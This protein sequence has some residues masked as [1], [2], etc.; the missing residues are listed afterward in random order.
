[1]GTSAQKQLSIIIAGDFLAGDAERRWTST[2]FGCLP[3][4]GFFKGLANPPS[5]LLAGMPTAIVWYRRRCHLFSALFQGLGDAPFRCDCGRTVA[6][7]INLKI[8][9][10]DSHGGIAVFKMANLY[11]SNIS[12]IKIKIFLYNLII[13]TCWFFIACYF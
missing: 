4:G 8:I 5:P 7:N 13:I 3:G 2:R 9:N 1:L 11:K 12:P 10:G 6:E